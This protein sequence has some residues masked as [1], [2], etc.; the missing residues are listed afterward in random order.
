MYI[1]GP[2]RL[3]KSILYGPDDDALHSGLLRSWA[4]PSSSFLDDHTFPKLVLY[5]F[6]EGEAERHRPGSTR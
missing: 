4:S 6:P 1:P 5:P 3:N 2:H